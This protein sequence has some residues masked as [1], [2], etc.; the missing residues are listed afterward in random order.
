MTL[1][2]ITQFIGMLVIFTAAYV[3]IINF[4][5]L[6]SGSD[7]KKPADNILRIIIVTF[8]LAAVIAMGICT[9]SCIERG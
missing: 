9:G 8:G 3:L 7:D 4:Q 5:K 6:L 2:T 1:T